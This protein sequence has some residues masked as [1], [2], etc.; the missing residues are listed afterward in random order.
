MHSSY[1]AIFFPQNNLAK[2]SISLAENQQV[3]QTLFQTFS[4]L[5]ETYS[6]ADPQQK[7]TSLQQQYAYAVPPQQPQY[8]YPQQQLPQYPAPQPQYAAPM[9]PAQPMAAPMQ[10]QAAVAPTGAAAAAPSPLPAVLPGA[11]GNIPYVYNDKQ[12]LPSAAPTTGYPIVWLFADNKT[13]DML[14]F[15]Y[16][17]ADGVMHVYNEIK[18]H[19]VTRQ[20]AFANEYWTILAADK[21]TVAVQPFKITQVWYTKR[22]QTKS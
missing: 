3:G 21:R 17:S 4:A 15:G 5:Y 19:S 8:A 10:Q 18:P 11:V 9:Q 22:G 7:L 12:Y 6:S 2:H 13:P 1:T 20:Q 16:Q 14:Y